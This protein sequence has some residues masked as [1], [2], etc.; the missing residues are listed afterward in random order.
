LKNQP[1]TTPF[2]LLGPGAPGAQAPYKGLDILDPLNRMKPG[3]IRPP[4][5][6]RPRP[7]Q[8]TPA[9]ISHIYELGLTSIAMSFHEAALENMQEVTTLA[10]DH[11]GAWTALAQLL[12]LAERDAEAEA[13]DAKAAAI[14]REATQWRDARDER[15]LALLQKLDRKLLQQIEQIP[16]EQRMTHLRDMLFTNPLDVVAMRY[17]SNEED[18]ADDS[19]TALNLLERAVTLAPAY[20]PARSDFARL[21]M[22][23][24]D[25]LRAYK[26]SGLLLAID[27]KNLNYRGL[28][29]DTAMQME[30]LPEAL[31]L[32]EGLLKEEPKNT[33][34]LN[35]YGNLL[36]TM[37]RREEAVQI[38]RTML[39]ISPGNGGAYYG[40]SELKSK[41]LT[42]A[43]ILDM[44]R[45]LT[46]GIDDLTSRKGMAYALGAA[47]ERARD[48][49]GSFEAYSFGAEACKEEAAGINK[50]Y[51]PKG[52]EE[53]LARFR[54]QFTA[55]NIARCEAPKGA[56][57][58]PVTPIFVIGMPRAGSTLVEQILAS[59]SLVEGTRELPVVSHLAGKIALSRAMVRSDVYP[60]RVMQM[61]RRE[62][63]A[64]GQ[65]CLNGIAEYRTT[66]L[67]Y[68]IDKRPWNW[69]DACFI[70]LILPN[71]K[72]IDI[73]R[74]AM[75][76]GFAMFKQH[77]PADAAFSYD[78]QHLGHYYRNYV[79]Y[80]DYMDTVMPGRILHV[81]YPK[82]VDDTETEIRRMLDYCGL[83]FE[84][85][86]L[87]FW[88]TDRA[89]LTPSAEQV[90]RP[91]FRD[92][93]EQW[94]NYEPWLGPLRESLGDLAEP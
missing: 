12:R 68:V 39:S 57:V 1:Q 90:R 60:E 10:P 53:R 46:E 67:P 37:G 93:L 56:P 4:M 49:R 88:E 89:V 44:H 87:R 42:T 8:K 79:E 69:I 32:Y 36:K 27:P 78:L 54:G 15:P 91:I 63:D 80:M 18:L 48:Y 83:P 11:A 2:T 59:H 94:R 71:A 33:K 85:G 19:I 29:A 55:E 40:L 64:L 25:H 14:D 72:F 23:E 28:R 77:L 52:L 20:V 61:N 3:V 84:E 73:R 13:A 76:A 50:S 66:T 17:L 9:Q 24:R 45:Y 34:L 75:A 41:Y 65:E 6:A 47:L 74:P 30:R 51:D 22:S 38:Y 62:L 86:C 82:L 43:D 70:H 58:P 31:E 92:A 26:Q 35:S 81:S 16:D 5:P 21:L 7:M